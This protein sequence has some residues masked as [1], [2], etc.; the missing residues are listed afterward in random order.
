MTPKE[1]FEFA[2]K[3]DAKM[4]DLKFTDLLGSWQHCSFP[5]ETWD[6]G[7]VRGR[8]WIRRVVG[9]G[10]AGYP[11]IGHAGRAGCVDGGARS[12]L[13]AADGE[14]DRQHRGP[15]HEGGLHARPQARGAQGGG[16]P[17]VDGDRRH[18][19]HRAGAGVLHLRHRAL[20]AERASRLLRDRLGGGRV[21]HGTLRG[22]EPGLQTELQGWL[23]PGEPDR[24]VSRSQRRD[25]I[26]AERHR[27]RRGGAPPRGGHGG[28]GRDRHGVCT[29]SADSR[30][31]SRGTSTS[32]ATWR[33]RRTRR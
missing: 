6:E 7:D 1:F 30:I 13:P 8:G 11:P 9:P 23:L 16:A 18:V 4:V 27:D 26:R 19:Q 3:H 2:K 5:I 22:A 33:R 24:H 10:L 14:R 15:R 28:P 31:T 20:R 25:G 17:E 32:F 21:E 12:V 29:A